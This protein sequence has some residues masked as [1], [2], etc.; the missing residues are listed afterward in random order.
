[1]II[2]SYRSSFTGSEAGFPVIAVARG[3]NIIGGGDWSEDRL[4][5]DFMRAYETNQPLEIRFPN[6]TRPWQH[7]ISLVDGYLS[8]LEGILSR[9]SADYNQAFNLG[10]LDGDSVSVSQVLSELSKQLPGVK[11]VTK[12]SSL[13]EA[14]K[15]GLNSELAS[16]SFGWN[17]SWEN[18]LV[19]EKTVEWYV[20][21]KL[22][23]ISAHDLCLEQIQAWERA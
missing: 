1:L 11:V 6:S 16:K 7:V 19:I 3:G 9:Q 21:N 17:P 5:P 12:A 2:A 23:Y 15:L 4:I 22:G 13:H 20:K 8:I 14:A 18:T 10:P